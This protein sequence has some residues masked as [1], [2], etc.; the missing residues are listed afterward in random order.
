VPSTAG[1]AG[2]AARI[3]L[4]TL[5]VRDVEAATRFYAALGWQVSSASVPGEVSFL[6]TAGARL[7]VWGREHLAADVRTSLP[8]PPAPVALAVNLGSPAEVDAAVEAWTAA[9]GSVVRA[10]HR[11]EWGGYSGYVADPDGH[12]WELAHNPGWPLG[13][14]GLPVLPPAAAAPPDPDGGPG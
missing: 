9:G 12:V 7:A 8:D 14:D 3:S 4:V 10:P 1:T 5:G 6:A 2:V 13:D 11:A